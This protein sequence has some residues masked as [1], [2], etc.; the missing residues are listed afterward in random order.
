MQGSRGA[1]PWCTFD[2]LAEPVA[3]QHLDQSSFQVLPLLDQTSR[4]VGGGIGSLL[5]PALL[6]PRPVCVLPGQ[7][8]SI[9]AGRTELSAAGGTARRLTIWAV[10]SNQKP[11]AMASCCLLDRAAIFKWGMLGG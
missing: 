2:R 3:P 11:P 1:A 4:D 10:G 5:L 8:G 9:G 6:C 7:S